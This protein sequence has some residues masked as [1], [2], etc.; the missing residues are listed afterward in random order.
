MQAALRVGLARG[1]PLSCTHQDERKK[2]GDKFSWNIGRATASCSRH[3]NYRGFHPA[4]LRED[5][6]AGVSFSQLVLTATDREALGRT[7]ENDTDKGFLSKLELAVSGS[8]S[9]LFPHLRAIILSTAPVGACPSAV[10]RLLWELPPSRGAPRKARSS[11]AAA[12]PALIATTKGVSLH[13][14]PGKP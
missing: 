4:H 8:P 7:D 3:T 2:W 9:S 1:V 12:R 6:D 14:D 11:T 13:A 5:E 10:V